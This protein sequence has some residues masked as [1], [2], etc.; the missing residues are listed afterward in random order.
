MPVR[1]FHPTEIICDYETHTFYAIDAFLAGVNM[2]HVDIHLE[3]PSIITK[4]D[5]LSIFLCG[6]V[7]RPRLF[8]YYRGCLKFMFQNS[9]LN[10]HCLFTADL[11]YSN[12]E[13]PT[14]NCREVHDT[15]FRN[16]HLFN[17]AFAMPVYV[18]QT[19]SVATM[20]NT[21]DQVLPNVASSNLN[22]I[23][24]I[25]RNNS[26]VAVIVYSR[27]AYII[28]LFSLVE[29][30]CRAEAEV[31]HQLLC[32]TMFDYVVAAYLN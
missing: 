27:T 13:I 22:H 2:L 17:E 7:S 32:D 10:S 29:Q 31:F 20:N 18:K 8:E 19:R 15:A 23:A 16:R 6:L 1:V 25:I 28:I 26:R 12:E 3:Y 24:E 30:N 14:W 4:Y 5:C 9:N 21:F 11:F